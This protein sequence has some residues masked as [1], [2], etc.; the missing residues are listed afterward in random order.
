MIKHL[1]E[2]TI[3]VSLFLRGYDGHQMSSQQA[4]VLLCDL[5]A[6]TL[7]EVSVAETVELIPTWFTSL[8]V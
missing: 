5:P 7:T 6:Q 8:Q 4:T 1:V 2:P 3:D